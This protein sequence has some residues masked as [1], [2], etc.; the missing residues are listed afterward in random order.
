MGGLSSCFTKGVG[1][2]VEAL[3]SYFG[4]RTTWNPKTTRLVF[5]T[6]RNHVRGAGAKSGL[7]LEN[8]GTL[9][10]V[11]PGAGASEN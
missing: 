6:W 8:I 2:F 11:Y 7:R 9:R 4:H 1:G 10:S 3:L 5:G